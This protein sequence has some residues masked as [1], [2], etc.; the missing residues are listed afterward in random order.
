MS[1]HKL[2]P[3]FE[4]LSF[5]THSV[6]EVAIGA[7]HQL[8]GQTV[9]LTV[10]EGLRQAEYDEGGTHIEDPPRLGCS[11]PPRHGRYIPLNILLKPPLRPLGVKKGL[12]SPF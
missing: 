6:I 8:G 9:D 1:N 12:R 3:T 7:S 10:G 11:G 5:F 4:T 2:V